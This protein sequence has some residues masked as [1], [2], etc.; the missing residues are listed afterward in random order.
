MARKK[1]S[2]ELN[3]ENVFVS[4]EAFAVN[5]QNIFSSEKIDTNGVKSILVET[6]GM[7]DL[8]DYK[9]G[10]DFLI[11]HYT[12]LVEMNNGYDMTLYNQSLEKLSMLRKFE[13]RIIDRIEHLIKNI[14]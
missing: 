13:K 9:K 1:K 11:V 8:I 4:N 12:N 6:M 3:N 10:C 7:A 14:E 2:E 5:N